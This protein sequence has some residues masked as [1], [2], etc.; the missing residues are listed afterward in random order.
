MAAHGIPVAPNNLLTRGFEGG[1]HIRMH[2][3]TYAI[4]ANFLV[5]SG[6]DTFSVFWFLFLLERS[7]KKPTGDG[8]DDGSG[9]GDAVM[10][11]MMG[12]ASLFTNCCSW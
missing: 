9:G 6:S 1:I 12:V 5:N 8:G 3:R 10:V 4:S 11:G 2:I 7:W